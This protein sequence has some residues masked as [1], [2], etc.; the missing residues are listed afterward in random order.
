MHCDG[1]ARVK[2]ISD[3]AYI[4]GPLRRNL[5]SSARVS[6]LFKDR[7]PALSRIFCVSLPSAPFD[8]KERTTIYMY[9][10]SSS[11][12]TYPITRSL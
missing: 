4:L 1:I 8:R 5:L 9:I 6:R 7:R 12:Y 2:A 11:Q 10:A 3:G